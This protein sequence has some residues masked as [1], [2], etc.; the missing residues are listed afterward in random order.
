MHFLRL[1]AAALLVQGYLQQGH[2]NFVVHNKNL[3][4]ASGK[5]E[6]SVAEITMKH[7]STIF[8]A[9]AES[10]PIVTASAIGN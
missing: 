6:K 2:A 8:N 7:W 5:I 9:I 1:H 3:L 10:V 4:K